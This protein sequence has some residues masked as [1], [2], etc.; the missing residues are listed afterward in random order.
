LPYQGSGFVAV[1]LD[2]R[3]QK[4]SVIGAGVSGCSLAS[5]A[6]DHGADVFVSD[7]KE[8][9]EERKKIFIEKNIRWEENGN[10][11]QMLDADKILVSSGISPNVPILKEAASR[12]VSLVGELD[13]VSPY[14]KGV[15]IGVTGSNGKTTT[16]SM[17]GYFLEKLGFE[18]ITAGNIGTPVADA[19]RSGKDFIVL[20]LSSFQLQWAEKFSCDIAIVTNLA[21]DH[22]D[23]HGSYE[24]YVSAKSNIIKCLKNGGAA[25]TQKRD[26]E[27]LNISSKEC[28]SYPLSW[29]KNDI[30]RGIFMDGENQ[31]AVLKNS[32]CDEEYKLFDFDEVKLLGTHNL[33]NAAMAVSALALLNINGIS[34]DVISSYSAL[35]HRCELVGV[36]DGITFVNDSKGTNVAA[37][38]AAMSSLPDMKVMILGGKGKG[39]DYSPLAQ[40]VKKYASSAVLLGAE[41]KK[42]AEALDA[43]EYK[44]YIFAESMEDAVEKAYHAARSGETVLLSPACTSWD[45][46]PNF[47]TRGIDFRNIVKEILKRAS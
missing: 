45:M 11:A 44:Q 9:K 19:A 35:D 46:Y 37:S 18:C 28:R 17:I 20:E 25:I 3:G 38:I 31:A 36:K 13:F 24:N 30:T 34:K 33:E 23:W 5:L 4:I 10:T 21:P 8:I 12:G 14:I 29:D 26:I 27:L 1:N 40:A 42:I 47:E 32:G 39:E 16:T 41:K 22:L 2:L 15:V 43:A 7:A 6:A